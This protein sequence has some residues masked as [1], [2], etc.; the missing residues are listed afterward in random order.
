MRDAFPTTPISL[1]IVG[2]ARS[3]TNTEVLA[4]GELLV[5]GHE[6][7]DKQRGLAQGCPISNSAFNAATTVIF[8]NPIGDPG[9]VHRMQYADNHMFVSKTAAEGDRAV[10]LA[11]Q[12]LHQADMGLKPHAG[13]VDLQ[14]PGT[15]LEIMGVLVSRGTTGLR[16]A[17]GETAW[18]G[19]AHDLRETYGREHP[20]QLARQMVLAWVTSY[21]PA[22]ES[23]GDATIVRIHRIMADVGLMEGPTDVEISRAI[24]LG[25]STWERL[26][27]GYGCG[28]RQTLPTVGGVGSL[29]ITRSP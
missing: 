13:P 10:M 28:D 6:G 8:N 5:R 16:F 27:T 12:S 20:S 17:V 25:N 1:A 9:K 23:V 19:L 22:F 2:L 29:E 4:F 7:P 15:Q 26:R 21:G 24:R 11:E 14:E 3:I 18:R